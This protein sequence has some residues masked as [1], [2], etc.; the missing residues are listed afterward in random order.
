M[1][2][3]RIPP[4]L[5]NFAGDKS[6]ELDSSEDSE[7][8]IM[9]KLDYVRKII[10]KSK[11]NPTIFIDGVDESDIIKLSALVIRTPDRNFQFIGVTN[12]VVQK[13]SIHKTIPIYLVFYY[14]TEYKCWTPV[15]YIFA[16]A[17][18][19]EI[20]EKM[21]D[22]IAKSSASLN[23]FQS[24]QYIE[25]IQR[26]GIYENEYNVKIAKLLAT[27]YGKIIELAETQNKIISL[28][29]EQITGQYDFAILMQSIKIS[30]LTVTISLQDD[31]WKKRDAQETRNN[32]LKELKERKKLPSQYSKTKSKHYNMYNH[33]RKPRPVKLNK[34]NNSIFN[35]KY[36]IKSM[37]SKKSVS[38]TSNK[39]SSKKADMPRET[40]TLHRKL[41]TD[42]SQFIVHPEG[43]RNLDFRYGSGVYDKSAPHGIKDKKDMHQAMED[44]TKDKKD[45]HHAMED[46]TKDMEDMMKDA[47]DTKDAENA[48]NNGGINSKHKN[49]SK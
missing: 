13:N 30:N 29:P 15:L 17:V 42:K 3:K 32:I 12:I 9:H 1:P 45:M 6:N 16:G 43:V 39:K 28:T 48:A 5:K 34:L 19:S 4:P 18:Y 7:D 46:M 22:D 38:K 8:Q 20:N 10:K 31:E 40:H 21:I 47:K 33:S 26:Y 35:R 37:K 49:T 36:P 25:S 41:N 24:N 44:M 2:P 23:D 14:R 27:H 11:D